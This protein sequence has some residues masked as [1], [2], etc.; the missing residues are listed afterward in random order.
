MATTERTPLPHHA[1]RCFGCG[2]K[3]PCGLGLMA[4]QEG[5]EVRGHVTFAKHHSGAPMFAHGGAVATALDDCLGFLIYVVG[6][7][8]VT[9]KL[10]VDYRKPVAIGVQYKLHAKLHHRRG[11]KIYTSIEMRDGA[12]KL[13]AEGK[14]LFLTVSLEHFTKNL[15]PEWREEARKR[16]IE[17]PW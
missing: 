13:V 14:G 6:E 1:P 4:W 12:D 10:E 5:D 3:N 7:P 15:P 16:G 2:P 17:L 9:A 11:R 8:A